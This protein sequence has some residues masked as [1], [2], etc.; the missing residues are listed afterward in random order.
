[1]TIFSNFQYGSFWS[2]A[3]LLTVK[4]DGIALAFNR[5]V[6]TRAVAHDISK[7][8]DRVKSYGIQGQIFGLISSFF[9]NKQLQV[10]L[11]V[12]TRISY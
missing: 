6:A 9:S 11:D 3:D 2:T 5:S 4:P 8:F 1:M 10:V 7:A 12:F